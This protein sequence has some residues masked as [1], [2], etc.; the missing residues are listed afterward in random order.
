MYQ[1][2]QSRARYFGMT[3]CLCTRFGQWQAAVRD[4]VHE[5][6]AESVFRSRLA[7]DGSRNFAFFV[8][9]LFRMPPP[10]TPARALATTILRTTES[11]FIARFGRG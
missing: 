8:V 11:W 4:T 2:L 3:S 5:S 9:L 6:D 1:H 7:R 10:D